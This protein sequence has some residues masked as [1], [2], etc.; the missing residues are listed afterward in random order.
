MKISEMNP[1]Q[2]VL[3]RIAKIEARTKE[4]REEFTADLNAARLGFSVIAARGDR[5]M[6]HEALLSVGAEVEAILTS[7][8]WAD[9]TTA[10]LE[11]KKYLTDKLTGCEPLSYSNQLRNAGELEIMK[12]RQEMLRVVVDVLRG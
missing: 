3:H 4:E 5:L 6:R 12:A 11:A 7:P 8:S 1:A 2:Y 9:P 10:L